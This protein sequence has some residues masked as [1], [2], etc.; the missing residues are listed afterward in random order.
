M[1]ESTIQF[2]MR[3]FAIII[4]VILCMG[5]GTLCFVIVRD[6]S[7]PLVSQ[8]L[9]DIKLIAI[10]G[11]SSVVVMVTG[12]SVITSIYQKA[13]N[14]SSTTNVQPPANGDG[15]IAPVPNQATAA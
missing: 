11:F 8:A 3:F 14:Q 5:M 7:D 15:P 1:N 9:D 13:L 6:G 12:R 10:G 2:V 4:G